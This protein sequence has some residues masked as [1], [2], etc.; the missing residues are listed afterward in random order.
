MASTSPSWAR[1][2]SPDD[3]TAHFDAGFVFAPRSALEVVGED[4]ALIVADPWHCRTPGI[5]LHTAEGVES[6]PVP[7]AD[8]YR[9]EAEDVAAAAAGQREPRL[10]RAD[11]IGQAATIEALYASAALGGT[12]VES[13]G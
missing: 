7:E 1:S 9:L 2:S 8:S 13:D 10:G 3:V 11:A 4:G 5:E 12:E 6:I